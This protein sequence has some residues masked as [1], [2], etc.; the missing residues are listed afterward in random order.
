MKARPAIRA[1]LIV[2]KR[3][4]W[5]ASGFS[6]VLSMVLIR[7]IS[8][9]RKPVMPKVCS[10][11]SNNPT[12]LS[13]HWCCGVIVLFFIW[14]RNSQR[15]HATSHSFRINACVHLSPVCCLFSDLRYVSCVSAKDLDSLPRENWCHPIASC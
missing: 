6:K 2:S 8:F 7:W 11:F 9:L 13:A 4:C 15:S 14:L 12:L 3:R 5:M 10:C 1:S